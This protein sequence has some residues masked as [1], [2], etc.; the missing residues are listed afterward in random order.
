MGKTSPERYSFGANGGELDYFV[1]T[2]GKESSPKKV[3]EDY[4]NLTGKMPLP[5]IWA[6]GNQQSRWSYFPES[7][8]REIADGFRKNKIPADVIYLDVDYMN[9]YRVFSWDKTRF[10]NP[11]K[12]I[13]D[14]KAEGFKTVLIID[15]GIKRD[16]NYSTYTDGLKN[17]IYVKNP[18]GSTLI[19]NAWAAES[20]F[21]DFTN[22]KAREWF[23]E[24]I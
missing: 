6:L 22:P 7:R 1:F 14:L 2:G 21:P 4:A 9:G 16:E 15:P 17:D 8:V 3:L 23:G 20:A 12:M 10:P 18:D 5:P 19:R 11:S 13:S 24:S